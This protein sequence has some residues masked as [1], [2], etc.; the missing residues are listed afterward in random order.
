[1]FFGRGG[2][3]HRCDILCGEKH[4]TCKW[5]KHEGEQS[6][7]DAH[8]C[9]QKEQGKIREERW[10]E[11]PTRKGGDVTLGPSWVYWE[12]RGWGGEIY[13]GEKEKREC[14]GGGD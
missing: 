8:H 3:G 2:K 13:R 10:Q 5:A 14:F 9:T 4:K 11:E 12:E 1:L 7:K 6:D